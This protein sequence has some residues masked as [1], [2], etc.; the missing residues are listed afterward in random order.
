MKD[1]P[2]LPANQLRQGLARKLPKHSL[3]VLQIANWQRRMR[4]RCPQLCLASSRYQWNS[5]VNL[6]RVQAQQQYLVC[7]FLSVLS[8]PR[9]HCVS[10]CRARWL[11]PCILL[12]CRVLLSWLQALFA[13]RPSANCM[14]AL[15]LRSYRVFNH[16]HCRRLQWN[17]QCK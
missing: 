6:A 7:P 5:L 3:N 13:L 10:C 14:L 9:L 8:G 2:A 15:R 4:R 11:L 1:S 16:N 12:A 17:M